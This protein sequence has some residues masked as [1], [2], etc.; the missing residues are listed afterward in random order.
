ME[1]GNC[2]AL[3]AIELWR[4]GWGR[5]LAFGKRVQDGLSENAIERYALQR[6]PVRTGDRLGREDTELAEMGDHG[7]F[8]ADRFVGSPAWRIHLEYVSVGRSAHEV[9]VVSVGTQERDVGDGNPVRSRDP[10]GKEIAQYNAHWRSIVASRRNRGDKCATVPWRLGVLL[11]VLI[12]RHADKVKR[13][14][15]HCPTALGMART[16]LSL[17]PNSPWCVRRRLRSLCLK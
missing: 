14:G 5:F 11:D 16:M 8:P 3:A 7:H 4:E 17:L 13:A 9:G 1:P 6:L 15:A 10:D 12:V 2:P